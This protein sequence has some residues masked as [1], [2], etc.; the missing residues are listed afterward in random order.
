MTD[1]NKDLYEDI[2]MIKQSL[3]DLPDIKQRLTAIENRINFWRG[4]VWAWSALFGLVGGG[5][6]AFVILKLFVN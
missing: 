6:G 3:M 2:G 1:F 5:G 4:A